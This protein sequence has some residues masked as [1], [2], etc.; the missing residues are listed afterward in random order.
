METVNRE[1]ANI[2]LPKFG[3]ASSI[4]LT[5]DGGLIHFN[6]GSQRMMG[7]R[8]AATWARLTATAAATADWDRYE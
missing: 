7:S 2:T 5:D 1:L 3:L 4:G 6:C 8:Y